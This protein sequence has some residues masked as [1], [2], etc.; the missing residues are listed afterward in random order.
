[1]TVKPIREMVIASVCEAMHWTFQ[2]YCEQPVWLIDTISI[3]MEEE[4]RYQEQNR[5][6]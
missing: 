4:N 2:E 3:K 5:S 1:M 6:K